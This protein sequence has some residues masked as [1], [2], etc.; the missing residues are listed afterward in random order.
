M[1][2][3]LVGTENEVRSQVTHSALRK[4]GVSSVSSE[5]HADSVQINGEVERVIYHGEPDF[6]VYIVRIQNKNP[7][8]S[9]AVK[10]SL[11]LDKGDAFIAQGVWSKYRGNDSFKASNI[12]QDMPKDTKSIAAWLRSSTVRG[13]G[14][15]TINS[16]VEYFGDNLPD[17]MANSDELVKSGIQR[18]KANTI[19]DEWCKRD[20]YSELFLYF[21]KYDIG[22]SLISKI[23]E[24]YGNDSKSRLDQ[25]P[26]DLSHI[27]GIGFKTA[28]QIALSMGWERASEKRVH[29]AVDWIMEECA[30]NKGH[31]GYPEKLFIRELS[32]RLNLDYNFIEKQYQNIVE[33]GALVSDE[34]TSLVYRPYMLFKE[35]YIAD[36]L[37]L[38]LDK[39]NKMNWTPI[40]GASRETIEHYIDI[41]Q[42]E[43]DLKPLDQ[44]QRSSVINALLNFA[45]VITG[46]P[47]T[48]KSTTMRVFVH[49]LKMFGITATLIAPTGKAAKRLSEAT[50]YYASTIHRLLKWDPRTKGFKHNEK[51]KLYCNWIV[52]DEVSMIGTPLSYDLLCALKPFCSITI[53]GD[54]DQLSSVEPGKVLHDVIS[55]GV[56]NVDRLLKT[57]RQGK[58]SG[59]TFAAHRINRGELPLEDG[60][61]EY[62]NFNLE[63]Y[64]DG[65][66]SLRRSLDLFCHELPM[67]GYDPMHDIQILTPMRK[68]ILGVESINQTIKRAINPDNGDERSVV[69]KNRSFTVGDRV[70]HL[71]N[72][73]GKVVFNGESGVV[74]KVEKGEGTHTAQGLRKKENNTIYVDYNGYNVLY[75]HEDINELT[76]AWAVTVHKSQGSEFPVVLFLYHG[77]HYVLLNRSIAY[78]AVTRAKAECW[79]IGP[80]RM[81]GHIVRTEADSFRYTGLAK[82]LNDNIV[83]EHQKQKFVTNNNGRPLESFPGGGPKTNVFSALR[84]NKMK[85]RTA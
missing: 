20:V 59:I 72:N 11:L 76:H 39:K 67:R 21:S 24:A 9:L 48:G 47:G 65:M 23:I 46:G 29:A 31:V 43:L 45:S 22:S 51:N 52:I 17:V 54:V 7:T 69:I 2:D 37:K 18:S 84:K 66:D 62:N 38:R 74:S 12:M 40:K 80:K 83:L 55:S 42:N 16:L 28:D 14:E 82:R 1:S 70:M 41:A 32:R 63:H 35:Q 81:L 44:H 75:T 49:V 27:S 26:W 64:D 25:N 61:L 58:G 15:A 50:G 77:D 6:R 85:T 13:V 73:Y 19:A 3:I 60:V 30:Y 5:S 36:Q 4:K 78:T 56:I 57:H 68:G 34:Q 71:K 79:M 53:V 10:S 8:F 33:R